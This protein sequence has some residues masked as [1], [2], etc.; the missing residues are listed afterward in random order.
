MSGDAQWQRW[1]TDQ[2]PDRQPRD[3][4]CRDHE[5]GDH[6]PPRVR[7]DKTMTLGMVA[8]SSFG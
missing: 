2:V 7:R 5:V 6:D 4:V 8:S 1:V 3:E